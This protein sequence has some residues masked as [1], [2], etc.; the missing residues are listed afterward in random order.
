MS[1]LLVFLKP[2]LIDCMNQGIKMSS[3]IS[4]S[5]KSV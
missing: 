2:F 4:V 1:D 3:S 5:M